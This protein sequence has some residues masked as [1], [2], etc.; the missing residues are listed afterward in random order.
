MQAVEVARWRWS[1]ERRFY[2]AMAF[3]MW[4]AVLLGFSRTYFLKPWFPELAHLSP[5]E[6]FFFYVHGVCFTAWMV[7]LVIQ[8][9]LVANRKVRLHRRIGWFGAGLAGSVV[10]V[11]TI[12]AL[13]AARRGFTGVPGSSLEFL[14]I[15]M[16]DLALFTL[17]VTWAVLARR[18]TQSHKRLM[19]LA[20]MGLLDAAVTR[21]PIGDMTVGIVGSMY[22]VTDLCVDLFLV[23]M[24]IWDI[25]SRGRLHRV[26]V[27]GGL[28]LI[29]SQPLRLVVSGTNF[30]LAIAKW[31]VGLLG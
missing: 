27:T 30:W 14:A 31:A 9:L 18:D 15:P 4:F 6:P 11:G 22:T 5:P 2:T 3:A 13:I 29:A 21:W 24:A 25:A 20:T 8:P 19:L 10:V 26:T 16:T 28:I 7:L 12:G 17:F 23:P 1:K